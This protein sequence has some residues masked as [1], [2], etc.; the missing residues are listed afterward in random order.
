MLLFSHLFFWAF[1]IVD[2]PFSSPLHLLRA[3]QTRVSSLLLGDQ[4][5]HHPPPHIRAGVSLAEKIEKMTP[6]QESN[7]IKKE[8]D[9][10]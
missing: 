2:C 10:Q 3:P 5:T 7:G 1:P 4:T 6:G 8:R 9:R